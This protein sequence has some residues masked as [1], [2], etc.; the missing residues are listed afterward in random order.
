MAPGQRYL[1]PQVFLAFRQPVRAGPE[2]TEGLARSGRQRRADPASC[3]DCNWGRLGLTIGLTDRK[4]AGNV[5]SAKKSENITSKRNEG[6]HKN[7]FQ[8]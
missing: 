3:R 5:T 2:D 6:F 7:T 4:R 1:S 8:V